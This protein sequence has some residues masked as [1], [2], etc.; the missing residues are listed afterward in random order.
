MRHSHVFLNRKGFV[1][2]HKPNRTG[3][4]SQTGQGTGGRRRST[5]IDLC[6]CAMINSQKMDSRNKVSV[7]NLCEKGLTRRG[8]PLRVALWGAR[9]KSWNRINTEMQSR[10]AFPSPPSAAAAAAAATCCTRL[11]QS[12]LARSAL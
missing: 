6:R 4:L 8:R 1:M 9:W 10:Y 12:L 11:S 2:K 5:I 3:K 7:I